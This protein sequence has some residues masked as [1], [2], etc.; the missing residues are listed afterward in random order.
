MKNLTISLPLFLADRKT[1][2]KKVLY[3]KK[4]F[5]DFGFCHQVFL[6]FL[7]L[8]GCETKNICKEKKLRDEYNQKRTVTICYYVI[9]SVSTRRK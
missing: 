3:L 1:S 9:T 8:P 5:H 2:D 6:F 7:N 4:L